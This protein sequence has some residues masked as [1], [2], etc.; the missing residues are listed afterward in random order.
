MPELLPVSD[1]RI[2]VPI[3]A[4]IGSAFCFSE[5]TV[6][7]VVASVY[8]EQVGNRL[9]PSLISEEE[10]VSANLDVDIH[11][12][13]RMPSL[14]LGAPRSACAFITIGSLKRQRDPPLTS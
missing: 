11:F 7:F 8:E 3:V 1:L 4:R 2:H 9:L 12:H 5:N 10:L 13:E 14:R 6:Q